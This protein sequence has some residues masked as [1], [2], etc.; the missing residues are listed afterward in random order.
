MIWRN[1]HTTLRLHFQGQSIRFPQKSQV[2]QPPDLKMEQ[3]IQIM[4]ILPDPN[5][6]DTP[7]DQISKKDNLAPT[8]SK[9]YQWPLSP[10][11][12]SRLKK[13]SRIDAFS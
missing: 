13:E 10:D 7:D 8:P 6:S 4:T 9:L 2:A 5:T 11:F 1:I 12:F 3:L